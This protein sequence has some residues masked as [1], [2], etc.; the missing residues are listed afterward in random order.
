MSPRVSIYPVLDQWVLVITGNGHL[1]Y[2]FTAK[3][4]LSCIGVASSLQLHI[5]NID[6]LPLTQYLNQG[7]SR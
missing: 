5:S 6:E 2:S 1:Y 3:R 4:L 7:V